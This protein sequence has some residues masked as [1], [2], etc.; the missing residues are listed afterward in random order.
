[1]VACCTRQSYQRF[2]LG[3]WARTRVS[4]V[5]LFS[6]QR[7]HRRIIWTKLAMVRGIKKKKEQNHTY[8]SRDLRV[9]PSGF[10]CGADSRNCTHDWGNSWYTYVLVF[11]VVNW[12]FFYVFLFFSKL[13]QNYFMKR[14]QGYMFDQT[15][16]LRKW[17]SMSL[18]STFDRF[19]E[20]NGFLLSR[21][22]STEIGY[23]YVLRFEQTA[24]EPLASQ[25]VTTTFRTMCDERC[26][27]AALRP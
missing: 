17:Y 8:F 11:H 20:L 24:G 1:M 9:S 15:N 2:W 16:D 13:N 22:R 6:T 26:R 23:I 21:P 19:N 7:A 27:N 3:R 25:K 5:R 12:P 18:P 14:V 10:N 4:S